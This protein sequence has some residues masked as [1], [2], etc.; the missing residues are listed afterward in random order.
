MI[1]GGGSCWLYTCRS[2]PVNS[3]A[4]DLHLGSANCFGVAL[5]NFF[6]IFLSQCI[7]CH[8]LIAC[9]HRRASF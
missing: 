3:L 4:S 2:S 7:F 5:L 8:Q 6:G 1:H 9:T